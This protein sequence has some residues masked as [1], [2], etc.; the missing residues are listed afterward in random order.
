MCL[1]CF[2]YFEGEPLRARGD[3]LLCELVERARELVLDM[4]DL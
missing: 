3:S 1:I 4:S 2:G